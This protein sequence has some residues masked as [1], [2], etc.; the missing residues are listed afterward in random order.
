MNQSMSIRIHYQT[1]HDLF[2]IVFDCENDPKIPQTHNQTHN[3]NNNRK[4]R[5]VSNRLKP[6]T[7]KQMKRTKVFNEKKPQRSTK[8]RLPKKNTNFKK[9]KLL[10]FKSIIWTYFSILSI[11][12]RFSLLLVWSYFFTVACILKLK[13]SS[14]YLCK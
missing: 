7:N 12:N 14:L 3:F 10:S 13:T 2:S 5:N 1:Y 6:N 11:E 9:K 4:T 8:I